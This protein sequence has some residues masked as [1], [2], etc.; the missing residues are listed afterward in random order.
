MQIRDLVRGGSLETDKSVEMSAPPLANIAWEAHT[1]E[2]QAVP[3]GSQ[4]LNPALQ[5]LDLKPPKL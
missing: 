4:T 3:S 1:P 5:T 2:L